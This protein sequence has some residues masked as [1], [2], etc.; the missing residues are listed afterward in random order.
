M[1]F[2]EARELK[3]GTVLTYLHYFDQDPDIIEVLQ[4]KKIPSLPNMVDGSKR[5]RFDLVYKTLYSPADRGPTYE[6]E[7]MFLGGEGGDW[8]VSNYIDQLSL[9]SCADLET[10]IADAR[11]AENDIQ[12]RI[13]YLWSKRWP[14]PAD[15]PKKTD[16]Q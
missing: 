5:F 8:P 9:S 16:N 3:P 13:A 2:N 4:V 10:V 7:E 14:M 11:E 6:P 12:K 1:D 15:G